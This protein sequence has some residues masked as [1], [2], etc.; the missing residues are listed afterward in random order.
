MLGVT[1]TSTLSM[2]KH[3]NTAISA[4]A[5]TLFALKT[6][7]AHGMKNSCLQTVYKSVAVAKLQYGASAW[8]GVRQPA[9]Q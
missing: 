5:Q 4:C 3:V 9:R 8:R 6:L 2:S 7:R 1:L